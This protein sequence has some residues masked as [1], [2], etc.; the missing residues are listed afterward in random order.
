VGVT[1]LSQHDLDAIPVGERDTK[2]G[3]LKHCAAGDSE[4]TLY[5]HQSASAESSRIE[6][7]R[8]QN[9]KSGS[10]E[11]TSIIEMRKLREDFCFIGLDL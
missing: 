11:Q 4:I 9:L 10:L 6:R 7:G 1:A 3:P 8:Q 5:V 2:L